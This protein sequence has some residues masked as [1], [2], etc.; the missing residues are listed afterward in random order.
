MS[1]LNALEQMEIRIE[2][3]AAAVRLLDSKAN[4]A[5]DNALYFEGGQHDPEEMA[6]ARVAAGAYGDAS[7][8]VYA[9]YNELLTKYEDMKGD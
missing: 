9:I 4:E 1:I 6:I 2:V 3:L 8:A 5:K 7:N